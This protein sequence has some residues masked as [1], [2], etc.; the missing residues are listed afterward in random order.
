[1][2]RRGPHPPAGALGERDHRASMCAA[3]HVRPSH[4]HHSM[5]AST[6]TR[7]VVCARWRAAAQ[8]PPPPSPSTDKHAPRSTDKVAWQL[9][10]AIGAAVALRASAATGVHAH[11]SRSHAVCRIRGLNG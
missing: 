6:V 9:L 10:E 11:S 5:G 4:E 2:R 7:R 3:E 8:P 1:L